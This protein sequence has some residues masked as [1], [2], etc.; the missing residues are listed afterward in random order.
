[1]LMTANRIDRVFGR[2]RAEGRPALILYLTAGFPDAETTRRLLPA[3]ET[4]GADLIELGVPFSDPIADGPTIQRA[5]AKAL[6]GGMTFDR[7]LGILRDFRR[8]SELP[9]I[10][11][12]AYNPFLR[13]GIAENVQLAAEAGADGFLAA[14]LPV[15]ECAELRDA[16]AGRGL[17][18]VLLAAPTSPEERLRSICANSTGFV[19]CISLKG[20]TGARA[21]IAAD[22]GEYLGRVRRVSPVPVAVGFGINTPEQAARFAPMAD[23]IVVGSG[24]IATIEKAANEGSGL[25]AAA[26]AYVR[27]L[28]GALK[29]HVP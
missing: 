21:D 9:V 5:S 23:G 11:F 14:D 29:P 17:K 26:G 16:A 18:L 6:E 27:S 4:A 19:Y 2:C 1:M 20:I 3:L 24:L 10:L 7:T 13:K 12:G 28:A 22:V 25:V 15:E 8:S